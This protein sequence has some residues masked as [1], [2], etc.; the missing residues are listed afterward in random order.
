MRYSAGCQ[1]VTCLE[2][3]NP[4]TAFSNGAEKFGNLAYK[5]LMDFIGRKPTP[6]GR[7]KQNTDWTS[8]EKVAISQDGLG[9]QYCQHHHKSPGQFQGLRVGA[10]ECGYKIDSFTSVNFFLNV[11]E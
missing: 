1:S 10:M 6:A 2:G 5:S 3:L 8:I 11:D 7:A 4:S 9:V